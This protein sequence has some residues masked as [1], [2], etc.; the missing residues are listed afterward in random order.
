M[1][2]LVHNPKWEAFMHF[3]LLLSKSIYIV[4]VLVLLLTGSAFAVNSNPFDE[5][6]KLHDYA[7]RAIQAVQSKN[8]TVLKVDKVDEKEIESVYQYLRTQL[9]KPIKIWQIVLLD[10]PRLRL[11]RNDIYAHHGRPF[12]SADLDAYFR[13]FNWYKPDNNFTES[14]LSLIDNDNISSIT[15]VE[16]IKFHHHERLGEV[17]KFSK[18]DHSKSERDDEKA[19]NVTG[20]DGS[21]MRSFTGCCGSSSGTT[22]IFNKNG[23]QFSSSFGSEGKGNGSMEYIMPLWGNN[24]VAWIIGETKKSKSENSP[25]IYDRIA[26]LNDT[27]KPFIDLHMPYGSLPTGD[28]LDQIGLNQLVL[29]SSNVLY[30]YTTDREDIYNGGMQYLV[31]IKSDLPFMPNVKDLFIW[32]A[33]ENTEI[34]TTKKDNSFVPVR[35]PEVLWNKEIDGIDPIIVQDRI[36]FIKH[37][38]NSPDLFSSVDKLSGREIY[39]YQLPVKVNRDLGRDQK[40]YAVAD[41]TLIVVENHNTLHFMNI[42]NGRLIKT[43]SLDDLGK[44]LNIPIARQMNFSTTDILSYNNIILYGRILAGFTNEDQNKELYLVA[45]DSKANLLWNYN[46][47]VKDYGGFDRNGRFR[48]VHFIADAVCFITEKNGCD[49]ID[50]RSGKHISNKKFSEF[51]LEPDLSSENQIFPGLVWQDRNKGD[52]YFKPKILHKDNNYI[53]LK[54]TTRYWAIGEEALYEYLRRANKL[55]VGPKK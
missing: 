17:I 52:N 28:Y 38:K 25:K 40:G 51:E 4:A 26:I 33:P 47:R 39:S 36:Y 7:E 48:F 14:N 3:S 37:M 46:T 30:C 35:N 9:A 8:P 23:L 29:I 1:R 6:P 44:K 2:T 34:K 21:I 5:I 43:I 22:K 32:R 15:R 50:I 27:G 20:I 13:S 41:N 11:L 16:Y 24:L 10:Y 54:G 42:D 18:I 31:L 45:F 55:V 12:T 49:L 19:V 53:F